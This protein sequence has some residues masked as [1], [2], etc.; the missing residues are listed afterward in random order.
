MSTHHSHPD[1]IK[2]LKRAEGHLKSIILMLEGGRPCLD[3]A[4]QLQAV[5]GHADDRNG[6]YFP[7]RQQSGIAETGEIHRVATFDMSGQRIQRGMARDR[8]RGAA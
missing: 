5:L 2:R 3:I 4:Q 7:Q 1:I 8:E 6:R